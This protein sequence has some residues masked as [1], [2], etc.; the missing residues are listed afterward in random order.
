MAGADV[1]ELK[2]LSCQKAVSVKAVDGQLIDELVGCAQGRG[3]AID[4]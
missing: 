3:P 1:A 4:R 2:R